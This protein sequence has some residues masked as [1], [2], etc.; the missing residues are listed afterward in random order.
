[1]R[2]TGVL[3]AAFLA[4]GFGTQEV[5]LETERLPLGIAP[6]KRK[7]VRTRRYSARKDQTLWLDI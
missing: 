1:M 3:T 4:S 5:L 2:L 7:T 6:K